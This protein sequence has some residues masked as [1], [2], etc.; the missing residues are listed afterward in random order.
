MNDFDKTQMH[1][2][3]EVAAVRKFKAS[4]REFIL[5][6]PNATADQMERFA[7]NALVEVGLKSKS[8]S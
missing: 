8:T 7:D 1:D 2:H 4:M 3:D 5:K 6:N